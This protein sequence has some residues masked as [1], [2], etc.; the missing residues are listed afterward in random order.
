MRESRSYGSVRGALS[1]GRP[2]RD[3]RFPSQQLSFERDDRRKGDGKTR[4]MAECAALLRFSAL[5]SASEWLA[6]IFRRA[7]AAPPSRP[8][9]PGKGDHGLP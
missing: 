1:N 8:W 6:M 3:P 4:L 9:L 2:Y 5:H 7:V